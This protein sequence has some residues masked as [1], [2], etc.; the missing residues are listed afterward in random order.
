MMNQA[1]PA[2]PKPL[3]KESYLAAIQNSL[4]SKLFRNFY[5]EI[6]GEKQD[7]MRGGELSCAFFVS[8]LATLFGLCSKVHGTVKGA[9]EDLAQ[10]GWTKVKKPKPGAILVWEALDFGGESHQH[11]G[12]WVGQDEAISNSTNKRTPAKHHWT[13]EGKRKVLAIWWNKKLN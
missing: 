3:I 13:F 11:I 10:S 6:D 7:I 12:F 5:A 4:G 8:S 2:K 9:T 1:P